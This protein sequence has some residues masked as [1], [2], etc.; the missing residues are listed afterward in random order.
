MWH[1][2]RIVVLKPGGKRMLGRPRHRWQ[3]DNVMDFASKMGGQRVDSCGS[4]YG[5]GV[6]CCEEDIGN[7]QISLNAGNLLTSFSSRNLFCGVH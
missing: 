3:D 6:G 4:G 2:W 1:V 5:Q 7:L